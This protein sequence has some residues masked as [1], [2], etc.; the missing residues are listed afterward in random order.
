MANAIARGAEKVEAKDVGDRPNERAETISK[1]G[2]GA[3]QN[4]LKSVMARKRAV[5]AN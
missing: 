4:A 2:S 1:S 5:G 3:K